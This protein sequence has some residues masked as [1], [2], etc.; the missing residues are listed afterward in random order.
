MH[1]FDFED[2]IS[3]SLSHGLINDYCARKLMSLK[4][5]HL[6]E[7]LWQ[8]ALDDHM[9]A[10]KAGVTSDKDFSIFFYIDLFV[11]DLSKDA[12]GTKLTTEEREE[13]KKYLF[14]NRKGLN[15]TDIESFKSA[16]QIWADSHDEFSKS[17]HPNTGGVSTH[18]P[19]H[20]LV[21]W[22]DLLS[23]VIGLTQAG[24]KHD[25][26]L[27]KVSSM[28]SNPEK[29]NF[30]LWANYSLN[31][32]FDKYD[33]NSII[34]GREQQL[35]T[36][37]LRMKPKIA[38]DGQYY[39]IP[40]LINPQEQSPTIEMPA[41]DH[42]Y[43]EHYAL[44]FESARNKLMS[45]VFAIDK[46]LEKYRKVLKSDQMDSVEE[47][48]G[49]L[50]K[51]IRKLRL[52]ST[53]KD[54]IIKTANILSKLEFREVANELIAI[55]ADEVPE[56]DVATKVVE[57]ATK[58]VPPE[59]REKALDDAIS[60]L[61][62]ISS[63]LKNRDLIRSLAEIDLML[64]KMRM[65]SFFPEIQEAQ[66][67]LIDAFGYASNKVEDLLPKLRGG[68]QTQP[69]IVSE[70]AKPTKES[71]AE[72]PSSDQMQLGDEVKQMSADI[73]AKETAPTKPV[74]PKPAPPKKT[75][76]PP[77]EDVEDEPVSL[78]NIPGIE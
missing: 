1:N 69:D 19:P 42:E 31:H 59:Q 18:K 10:T 74:A 40:K 54:S 14:D 77:E 15:L 75:I 39:Y 63:V 66:S 24:L 4:K 35:R 49:N 44:D 57:R 26:A 28:L 7:S 67:K 23:K 5:E 29:Y 73:R 51:N 20:D 41:M 30:L 38:S 47:A 55:A 50:R 36:E 45:R 53:Q 71:P 22:K 37:A 52:A 16:A 68:L 33:I 32:E 6:T 27:S 3:L 60:R 9:E 25:V 34:R 72:E 70:P 76:A 12:F 43:D 8:Q 56:A 58:P 65:S 62:D 17:A 48:L 46:L 64:H 78:R 2:E 61:T 11:D 13:F 21:K